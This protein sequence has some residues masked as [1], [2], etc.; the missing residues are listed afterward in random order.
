MERLTIKPMELLLFDCERW[1][2]ARVHGFITAPAEAHRWPSVCVE[3]MD[4]WKACIFQD[5]TSSLK[6]DN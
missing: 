5:V 1:G 3:C 2:L 6:T 4:Q